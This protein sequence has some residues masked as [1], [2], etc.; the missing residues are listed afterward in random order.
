MAAS[1][2]DVVSR[3]FEPDPLRAFA[4]DRRIRGDLI[5]SLHH[6][7]GVYDEELSLRDDS[8]ERFVANLSR[9]KVHPLAYSYY[10]DTVVALEG[11]KPSEAKSAWRH[12]LATPFVEQAL[13]IRDLGDPTTDTLAQHY[14]RHYLSGSGIECPVYSPRPEES[15]ASR[16]MISEAMVLIEHTD[17]LLAQEI[18]ALICE[19]LLA[20]GSTDKSSMTFDGASS[21][22]LWGGILLNALRRGGA[23]EMAQMLAHESAHGLLYGWAL[24]GPLVLN[25]DEER[26]PSPLRR[27]P[28]PMEGIYHATFVSA[29]MARCVHK[30]LTADVLDHDQ[31]VQAKLDFATNKMA[32]RRGYETIKKHAK[33]SS[34]GQDLISN[35]HAA[36]VALDHE[37]G[38]D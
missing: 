2:C 35:T 7:V 25:G 16:A 28:R 5:D 27:D 17:P 10:F 1:G 12:L 15:A 30:L 18:R 34:L 19:I 37:L 32:F 26:Y 21:F 8:Y 23:L 14:V 29:R 3:E 13:R 31:T 22:M 38:K 33:L 20:G 11:E 24:E 6:I 9:K 36:L 4:F